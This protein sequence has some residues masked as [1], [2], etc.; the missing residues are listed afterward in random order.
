MHY[1]KPL[2]AST[3]ALLLGASALANTIDIA[4]VKVEDSATVAG[5]KLQLNGAGIR[6]KGPFKVY[7]AELYTSKKIASLDE[8]LAAPGPK[9]MTLVMTR[10][11]EA[12][13]FGK[14]LTRGMEDNNPKAEMSKLVSGLMK[15]SELFTVHKSFV[16]GDVII[17]DWLPGTGLVV[18]VKGKV[19]PE[20][21]KEPEFFKALMGIWLGPSP[22][23]WKLKDNLLGDMSS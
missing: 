19:Q 16:P 3:L 12:G 15:M 8:L 7:V 11:I 1:M 20:T 14:L 17:M 2:L 21:F 13:P 5:T 23:Y 6:Y 9:R 10:D 18:T 4:G 22:A